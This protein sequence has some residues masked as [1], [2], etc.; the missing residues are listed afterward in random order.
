MRLRTAFKLAVLGVVLFNAVSCSSTQTDL[1]IPTKLTEA[2]IEA[3]TGL[4]IGG[5]C[6][7]IPL[8]FDKIKGDYN[9]ATCSTS[10]THLD[11]NKSIESGDY[12][13]RVDP[14][15]IICAQN[16]IRLLPNQ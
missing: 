7:T 9:S 6:G 15:V 2:Q 5:R 13:M 3:A 1:P 8:F 14:A 11:C 4:K 12:V 10:D 16:R